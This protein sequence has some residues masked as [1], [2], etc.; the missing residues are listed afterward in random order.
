MNSTDSQS[1][2]APTSQQIKKILAPVEYSAC[3]NDACKYAIKIAC[4]LRAEIK[5]FHTYYSPAFDLIELAGAVQ[6]Q[7]QLR[8][9]VTVSLEET[10]KKTIEN[11]INDLKS[12]I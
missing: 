9:E 6:T 4:K 3:S 5:F 7:S 8:D 12:Y 2:S 1:A 11:F 10:E